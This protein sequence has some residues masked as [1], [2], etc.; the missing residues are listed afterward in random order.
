MRQTK[1]V[2][3]EQSWVWLQDGV[4]KRETESVI[5]AVQ[6]QSIRTNLVKAKID[7]S[8]KDCVRLRKKADEIV[9]HDVSGCSKLAQK[10]YKRRYDNLGKI[11]HWNLARKYKFEAGDKWYVHDPES[12][13][14]NED[15]KILWDFS[16]QTDHVIEAQR[17]DLVV[18]DKKRRTSK[19]IDFTVPG[20]KE[21]IEKY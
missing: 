8:Q 19:I 3:S 16:I 18:V 12:V 1:E 2:R 4:L 21:K 13:L 14:E 11:V 7:K 6:N 20:E 9:D 17:P 5:V 15:Y 10:E